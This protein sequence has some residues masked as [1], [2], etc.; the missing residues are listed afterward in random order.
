MLILFSY[1]VLALS[2]CITAPF[3]NVRF[4]RNIVQVNT[5][6]VILF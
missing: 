6:G 2:A 3:S 5:L 4:Q 1:Y